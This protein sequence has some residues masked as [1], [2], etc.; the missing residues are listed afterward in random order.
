MQKTRVEVVSNGGLK[1]IS[2][3]SEYRMLHRLIKSHKIAV[4]ARRGYNIQAIVQALNINPK[5]ARKWLET[6]KIQEAI[7]EEMEYYI[8]KMQET[9]AQDWRQWA[10]QVELAQKN[11]DTDIKGGNQT[12]NIVIVKTKDEFKVIEYDKS[13]E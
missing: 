12:N 6:P 8:Q 13:Q 2:K 1:Y 10:K 5:T 4:A 7:A 9:G 3:K 11:T